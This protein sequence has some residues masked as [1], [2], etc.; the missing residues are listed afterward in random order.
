MTIKCKG[1]TKG[2]GHRI[3]SRK[4]LR[5]CWDCCKGGKLQGMVNGR[6]KEERKAKRSLDKN[7]ETKEKEEKEE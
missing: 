6:E 4:I 2:S 3:G 1:K 5:K 7:Y